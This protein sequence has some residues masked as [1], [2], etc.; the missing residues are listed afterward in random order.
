M[1]PKKTLVLNREI[2]E[3]YPYVVSNTHLLAASKKSSTL[4]RHDSNFTY[5]TRLFF[6]P[7]DSAES[8]LS[9]R[10]KTSAVLMISAPN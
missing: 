5:R 1:R 2:V 4:T 10:A 7:I 3:K 8:Q 6:A 9:I